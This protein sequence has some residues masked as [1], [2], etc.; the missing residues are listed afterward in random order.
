M[1]ELMSTPSKMGILPFLDVWIIIYQMMTRAMLR[2]VST[3][4]RLGT[5]QGTFRPCGEP[6]ARRN[7]QLSDT[8]RQK[9]RTMSQ[10]IDGG[11][12]YEKNG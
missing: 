7:T 11:C 5:A 9:K 6:L 12:R 2:C 3:L 8:V 1:A 4:W 10:D